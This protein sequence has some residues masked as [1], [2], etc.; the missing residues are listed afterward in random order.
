MTEVL[1]RYGDHAPVPP[2][3]TCG[4]CPA[5]VAL[6]TDH[7]HKHGWVRG[8]LCIRHNSRM[9][10]IDRGVAPSAVGDVGALV[11]Y[12]RHCPDCPAIVAGDLVPMSGRTAFTWRLTDEQVLTL[13][14]LTL[15][16]KREAGR[17]KLDRAELMA[18]LVDLA[19]DQPAV[20]ALLVARL[21]G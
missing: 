11:A 21:R 5:T 19:I 13:D 14:D 2:G 12:A 17:V 6:V 15:R 7:C 1:I 8:V 18:V 10:L 9:A 20:F 4:V 16:L 3:A